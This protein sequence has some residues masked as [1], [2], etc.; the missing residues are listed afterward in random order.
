M[1]V[2]CLDFSTGQMIND[3]DHSYTHSQVTKLDLVIRVRDLDDNEPEFSELDKRMS[4]NIS[5]YLEPNSTVTFLPM[6]RDRDTLPENTQVRYVLLPP[7]DAASSAVLDKFVLNETSGEL[8]LRDEL[9]SSERSFYELT[10]KATSRN[11]QDMDKR[12]N[13]RDPSQITLQLFVVSDRLTVEFEQ[14]NYQVSVK[15]EGK[16]AAVP[17]TSDKDDNDDDDDNNESND[18]DNDDDRFE[19]GHRMLDLKKRTTRSVLLDD[20]VLS[21]SGRADTSIFFARAH[22]IK[23]KLKR[24]LKF[25]IDMIKL[26]KYKQN[27]IIKL[28]NSLLNRFAFF[29]FFNLLIYDFK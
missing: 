9:E 21:K 14:Q 5:E 27:A 25:S 26:I 28:S 29:P 12:P 22:L 15:V 2:V 11:V 7:V 23:R 10:V 20:N 4:K 1:F 19:H 13:D 3:L 24:S 18:D 17:T 16:E 6:A 8:T